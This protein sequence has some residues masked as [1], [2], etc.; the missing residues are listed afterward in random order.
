MRSTQSAV[1][2][3]EMSAKT[4]ANAV[5]VERP[6]RILMIAPTSFFSDYGGHIR[7]LEEAYTLQ[8]M[9]HEVAIVTYYKGSNMPNLDIR[10]TAPLPWRPEYEVGS[11]RH[12][13][14]FDVYL[15]WQSLVEGLRFKP[16]VIHGHMHEGALIGGVL[17]KL[18]RRPLVFDFQGSMTA[19]MTD[20]NFL[21]KNGR[22]YRLAFRLEKLINKLPDAILTSSIKATRLLEGEFHLPPQKLVPL[23]DCANHRR[24]DP[25]KFSPEMKQ[26][27][28]RKL[29]VPDG[30]TVIAY[31]G[32]LTDYQGV[33]HLID[34]AARLKQAGENCHFLIMGYPNVAR[35]Q[36]MARQKNAA[37]VITFTGKVMY[38]NAPAYLSLGDIAVAPKMSTSEGS[39][40]LLNYM[41]LGQ[42]IVAY[43][44]AVH[45]EYLADLGVYAPSGNV[46]AFTEAIA[47]LLHQ[48]ER[49][50]AL[51]HQLR[52][53]ALQ[54]Y[55]WQKAGERI[56]ALYR[57]LTK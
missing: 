8:G 7:I 31:L 41:A 33:P 51:G 39:G 6:L 18:L 23:P 17:A 40:K 32:L 49:R 50:R 45:R 25:D 46:T 22:L 37:D 30:R 34:A 42:P 44:S 24:F 9:G 56:V 52:Q 36:Q 48:P 26:N 16:D 3:T 10:R 20:H 5:A 14:A 35:Y 4:E 28:R 12:K 11:S 19:E 29:G 13:I 2:E 43:D 55:S 57:R 47:M 27:L 54:V 21:R 1:S 15:A 53:R 38:Q